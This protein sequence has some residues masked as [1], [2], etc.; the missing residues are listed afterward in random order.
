MT[1]LLSRLAS[2]DGIVVVAELAPESPAGLPPAVA[3]PPAPIMTR[4]RAVERRVYLLMAVSESPR[5]RSHA[6]CTT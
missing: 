1:G 4:T 6:V 3:H 5:V 2:N